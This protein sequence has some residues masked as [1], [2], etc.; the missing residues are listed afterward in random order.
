MKIK[1]N[2]KGEFFYPRIEK[3]RLERGYTQK[4]VAY[5][6]GISQCTYSLYERG[7]RDMAST[8]LVGL[9]NLYKVSVS[10]IINK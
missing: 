3:L 7:I 8:I 10:Y 5:Y 2:K 4:Y 6:L 9:S 1:S